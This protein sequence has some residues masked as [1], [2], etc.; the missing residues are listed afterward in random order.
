[1]E[2]IQIVLE[3]LI[4]MTVHIVK[5]FIVV[6]I[7]VFVVIHHNA[8]FKMNVQ[9]QLNVILW[10]AVVT[11]ISVEIFQFAIQKMLVI[12]LLTVVKICIVE[13]NG[14]VMDSLVMMNHIVAHWNFVGT[15]VFVMIHGAQIFFI[16][17]PLYIAEIQLC[18][19]ILLNM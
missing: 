13:I 16:V 19:L 3:W 17:D 14:L 18:V 6:M 1:M 7:Q 4:A 8:I 12:L 9:I 11:L 2:T 5:M 15:L 10:L